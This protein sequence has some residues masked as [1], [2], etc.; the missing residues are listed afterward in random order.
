MP[1]QFYLGCDMQGR[2]SEPALNHEISG[3][4]GICR[5]IWRRFGGEPQ[6]V[7]VL[8]NIKCIGT[9]TK[10]APDMVVLTELGL[11]VIELKNY[12]GA[13]DCSNPDGPWFAGKKEIMGFRDAVGTKKSNPAKQVRHYAAIM[14]RQL[15]GGWLPHGAQTWQKMKVHTAVCFTN[16]LSDT[17]KCAQ[18]IIQ[19]YPPGR[20][21]EEWERLSVITPNEISDWVYS[22]RF[23]LTDGFYG[24][25]HTVCLTPEEVCRL[26]GRFFHGVPWQAMNHFMLSGPIVYAHLHLLDDDGKSVKT[27][28]LNQE[29]FLLGRADICEVQFE[30]EYSAVSRRHA[31][32]I[33]TPV[34]VQIEDAGSTH[35]TLIN[36][37]SCVKLTTLTDGDIISLGSA[38]PGQRLCRLRFNLARKVDISPTLLEKTL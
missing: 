36:G 27:F 32:M 17:S 38:A 19:N 25:Y 5:N 24:G 15:L 12:F 30:K 11:G 20:V 35:G 34:G 23:G 1:V 10:L 6:M 33:H 2:Y 9:G 21:L 37:I 29:E 28:R 3:V 31:R 13:I 7:A 16:L 26:A 22:L 18:D 4:I 8:V 14:R